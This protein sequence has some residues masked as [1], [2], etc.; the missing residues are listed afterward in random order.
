[1]SNINDIEKD[2]QG[3]QYQFKDIVSKCTTIDEIELIAGYLG[4]MLVAITSTDEG[5]AAEC[6][7]TIQNAKMRAGGK[8]IVPVEERQQ[9]LLEDMGLG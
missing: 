9:K 4:I 5:Q 1:M 2:M 6:L 3:I 7:E 8:E